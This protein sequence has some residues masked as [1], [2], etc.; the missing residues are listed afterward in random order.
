MFTKRSIIDVWDVPKYAPEVWC[1]S[2]FEKKTY[3]KYIAGSQQTFTC[4]KSTV[5]TLENGG[6]YVQS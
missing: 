4:S 1:Q 6:K 3:V 2:H 5:D